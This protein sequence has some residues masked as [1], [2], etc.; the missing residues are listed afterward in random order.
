VIIMKSVRPML[1]ACFIAVAIA[2]ALAQAKGVPAEQAIRQTLARKELFVLRKQADG[3]WK[4]THYSFS[5]APVA[6]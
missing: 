3:E 5:T 1:A 6:R 4:F 2:P